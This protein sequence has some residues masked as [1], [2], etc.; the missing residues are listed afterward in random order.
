[1]SLLDHEY[2][3]IQEY[4]N[5]LP[6]WWVWTFVATIVFTPLYVLHFHWGKGDLVAAEYQ[7]D[8]DA[9]NAA[10]AA[11][12]LAGGP[13][14]EASLLAMSHDAPTVEAGATLFRT[15]CVACH[16]DRAEG[17]IGPNLTDGYWLHGGTLLE[18]QRTI[19]EGVP[20]KGMLA[21]G[22]T[23]APEDVKRLAAYVGSLRGLDV[24][25][26]LGPQGSRV[27]S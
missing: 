17:R 12:A 6:A 2:D 15:N 22:K 13:V 8:V 20:D 24:P 26:P 3:G 23:L 25:G 5:P 18:I 27:G 19:T 4:D 14:T 11:R 10:E 9:Y 16:G 1:M 7:R 21:W